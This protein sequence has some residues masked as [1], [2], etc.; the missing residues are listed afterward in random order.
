MKK[1]GRANP[2][3]SN[4]NKYEKKD[5]LEGTDVNELVLMSGGYGKPLTSSLIDVPLGPMRQLKPAPK[6]NLHDTL[7]MRTN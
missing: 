3:A 4:R 2:L 7:G 5:A 6:F 1:Y